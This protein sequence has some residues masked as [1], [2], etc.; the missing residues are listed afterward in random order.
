LNYKLYKP[1]YQLDSDVHIFLIISG[2]KI[3][4]VW[5]VLQG[6]QPAQ[7]PALQSRLLF[8]LSAGT[9]FS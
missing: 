7:A 2:E 1:Y 5:G 8:A 9:S 4:G 3:A 6:V